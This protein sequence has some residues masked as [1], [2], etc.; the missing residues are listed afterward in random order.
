[1]FK[2]LK[3]AI[4]QAGDDKSW[5]VRHEL[6]K[7]FP[8][9][10][11]NFGTQIN[12]LI[13][14]YGNLIKDSEMEVRHMALE[15]LNYVLKHINAEKI[16]ISIIPNILQLQNES[17]THVKAL[18]GQGLGPIAKAVG[19]TVF[20]S[21]LGFMIE[22]LIKDENTD[23]K[24]GIAKS[25]YDIFVTSEGQLLTSTNNSIAV[26]LK[27]VKSWRLRETMFEVVAKLGIHFG[28]E[29]FKSHFDTLFFLY[30]TDLVSNV[31][32]DVL[33]YLEV[34]T[35]ITSSYCVESSEINGLFQL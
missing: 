7:I 10:I 18:I 2:A 26:L 31:R 20:N 35:F 33:K 27:D 34:I 13:P 1:M 28:P 12:E 4:I 14:T 32:E 29:I 5:R 6:A 25:L 9:I 21:K 19:Y 8:K 15:G 30:L 23:V 22:Q 11:E 17:S 16:T 24:L 3:I